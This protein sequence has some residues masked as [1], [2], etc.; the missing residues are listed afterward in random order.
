MTYIIINDNADLSLKVSHE[1]ATLTGNGVSRQAIFEQVMRAQGTMKTSYFNMCL[2][3]VMICLTAISAQ[4]NYRNV[5]LNPQ[6]THDSVWLKQTV[7]RYPHA[8]SNSE[9]RMDPSFFARNCINDTIKN[10]CHGAACPSWGPEQT[11]AI[12]WLVDFG[13]SEAIDSVTIYSRADF[14]HDNY[15]YKGKLN[16][17]DSSSISIRLDSTAKPQGYTFKRLVT[18][19]MRIDSLVWHIPNTWCAFTQV[20]VW[21]NDTLLTGLKQIRDPLR[22]QHFLVS[23]FDISRGPEQFLP[24]GKTVAPMQSTANRIQTPRIVRNARF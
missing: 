3:I 9:C 17:S 11:T 16:F 15:W 12:W 14:P 1:T 2:T 20:Q 22:M 13:K 5:A 6:D 10:T 19:W 24:N 18:K 21:G 7:K 8:R 4:T 23:S